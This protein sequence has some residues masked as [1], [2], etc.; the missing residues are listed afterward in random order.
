[1][2]IDPVATGEREADIL[3]ILTELNLIVE[4]WIRQRPAQWL[5]THKRWPDE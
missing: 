3:A 5:W 4:G 1:P 2:P